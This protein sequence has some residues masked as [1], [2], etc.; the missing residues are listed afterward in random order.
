[1]RTTE[2]LDTVTSHKAQVQLA[3]SEARVRQDGAVCA[4]C[5]PAH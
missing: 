2:Q 5:A 1:M 3:L 4:A